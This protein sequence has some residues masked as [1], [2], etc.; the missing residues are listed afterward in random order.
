[1]QSFFRSSCGSAGVETA[2]VLPAFLLITFGMIYFAYVLFLSHELNDSLRQ[3]ARYAMVHGSASE[4]PVSEAQ[5]EARAK[6]ASSFLDPQRLTVSAEFR[7]TN[8]P[9]STVVVQA[10]YRLPSFPMM[11]A[12]AFSIGRKV[13]LTVIQ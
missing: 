12:Y 2:I 11:S 3:A 9:G 5:I 10:S 7:P 8:A 6:Q 13:E 4:A 1:M